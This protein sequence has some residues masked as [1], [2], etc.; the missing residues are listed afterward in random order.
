MP[1]VTRSVSPRIVAVEPVEERE[2]VAQ[3][4]RHEEALAHVLFPAAP[5]SGGCG[6]VVEDLAAGVGALLDRI[7]EPAG[8]AVADLRGDAPDASGNGRPSLPE[9]LRHRQAEALANRL[10]DDGG[11]VHLEGVDLDGPDVVQVREDEDVRVAGRVGDGAVVVVPALGIV[12]R[13]RADERELDVGVRLP[14]PAGRR[15]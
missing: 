14:A 12:V 5:A 8:L 15:R 9:P 4:A 3:Q 6:G 11:R 2:P 7:D 1:T 13:H 10:L